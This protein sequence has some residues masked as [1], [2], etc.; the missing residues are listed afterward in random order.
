MPGWMDNMYGFAG[1]WAAVAKGVWRISYTSRRDI[2]FD[3][4]PCDF[5]SNTCILAAWSRGTGMTLP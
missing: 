4:V 3:L 5:V 2:K 1:F